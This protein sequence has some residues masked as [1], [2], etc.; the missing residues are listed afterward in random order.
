LWPHCA[1]KTTGSFTYLFRSASDTPVNNVTKGSEAIVWPTPPTLPIT[2]SPRGEGMYE[3]SH[4]TGRA[5]FHQALF[6]R[7]TPSPM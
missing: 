7:H 3:G 2:T 1:K 5:C 6:L 4:W